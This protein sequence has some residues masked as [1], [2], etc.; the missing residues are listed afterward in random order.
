VRWAHRGGRFNEERR[1]E[2]ALARCEIMK[3]PTLPD[4]ETRTALNTNIGV[5]KKPG[6]GGG[7]RYSFKVQGLDCAEEV[8]VLR[9]EVGPLVG[10]EDNLA[11]DVL[12]GRMTVLESALPASPDEII[13]ALRHDNVQEAELNAATPTPGQ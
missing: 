13:D 5:R 4:R 12:S 1:S 8:A 7:G 9:G 10:G 6:A 2:G 3:E 11:F